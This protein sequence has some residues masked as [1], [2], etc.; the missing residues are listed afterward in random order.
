MY[1]RYSRQIQIPEVNIDGQRKLEKAKVLILGAGGLGSPV[2]VYLVEAGIGS[3]TLID[4][5]VVDKTNLNRQFLYNENFIGKSKIEIALAFL[6]TLNQNV[7]IK[8][9]SEKISSENAENLLKGYDL[10]IDCLDN[11]K[12][13]YIVNTFAWKLKTPIFHAGISNFYGQLT[14]I[15]PDTTPCLECVFPDI[16]DAISPVFGYLAGIMGSMLVSEVVKYLLNLK[17]LLVNK[18]LLY[19]SL[20]LQYNIFNIKKRPICKICNNQLFK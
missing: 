7:E 18:L 1:T 6:K 3:V 15:I 9:I 17:P 20:N 4:F 8:G 19:D 11:F 13:R 12:T 16:Q 2:S 10:I 14:I 5:D